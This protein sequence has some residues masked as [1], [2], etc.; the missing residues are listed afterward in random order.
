MGE[1][2]RQNISVHGMGEAGTRVKTLKINEGDKCVPFFSLKGQKCT[3]WLDDLLV[4][5]LIDNGQTDKLSDKMGRQT[6]IMTGEQK[7]NTKLYCEKQHI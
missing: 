1:R 7:D 3:G 5:W 4:Y 6:V 2:R